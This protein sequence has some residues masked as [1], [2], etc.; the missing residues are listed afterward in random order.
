LD[1]RTL[2]GQ[3][4]GDLDTGGFFNALDHRNALERRGEIDD[5]RRLVGTV[6]RVGDLVAASDFLDHG[7]GANE[8]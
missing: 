6:G 4:G 3:I 7:C 2:R 8:K 1:V 5:H